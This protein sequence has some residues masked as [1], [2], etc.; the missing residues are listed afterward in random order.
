MALED[1]K[2]KMVSS[3][4]SGGICGIFEWLEVLVRKDKGSCEV[5]EFFGEFGGFLEC[6]ERLGP[7][8]NYFLE[9]E[10]PAP[11]SSRCR[12]RGE[13]YKKN[14]GFGAKFVR[15]NE[16]GIVFQWKILLNGSMGPWTGRHGRV[17]GGPA[18]NAD[19]GHGG[20]QPAWGAM[21][22]GALGARQRGLETKRAMRRSRG[23]LTGA[24]VVAERRHDG[25]EEWRLLELGAKSKWSKRELGRDR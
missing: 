15:Y 2:G 24:R 7:N 19:H 8:R 3:G 22:A 4:G 16:L 9:I 10:G 5:W 13:I 12:N 23:V 17:H 14:R 11:I 1:F 6:L 18:S 25:G 20:T 21:V